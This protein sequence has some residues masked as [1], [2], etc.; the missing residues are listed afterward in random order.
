[1]KVARLVDELDTAINAI[2]SE[3]SAMC[4]FWRQYGGILSRRSL[5]EQMVV[6]GTDQFDFWT[7]GEARRTTAL[8]KQEEVAEILEICELHVRQRR[9]VRRANGRGSGD[10]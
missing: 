1:M 6:R 5:T 3:W 2:F 8:A 4:S 9:R 7:D 10:E